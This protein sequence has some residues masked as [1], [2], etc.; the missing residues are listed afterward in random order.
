VES[1]SIDLVIIV[2][3]L[4]FVTLLG[5]RLSGR[6]QNSRDFFLGGRNLPW[7]AVC[8]SIVAT[9]TSTLTFISVPGLAYLTNLNFLQLALGYIIGRIIVSFVFLPAYF[10]GDLKTS[11]ELLYN[12]FGPEVRQLS[13]VLFL[14]T[15][16]L[17]DGV[18]LF[19]TAIPLAILTGWSMPM[20]IVLIAGFT[21]VYTSVGGIR[22]VVWID[23]LQ[24][25]IY[26]G[27]AFI[28]GIYILQHLPGGWSEVVS[29]AA[30]GN[31]FQ[32]I[33][34]GFGGSVSGFF[35]INYTLMSSLLGGAFLSM[36]SHGTDQIIVQR[37]LAC[38]SV[39]DSQKALIL[40]G[41][42]VFVQ[43]AV[44]LVLGLL[45]FA[46][47]HGASMRSDEIFPRFI[48]QSMP[49]GLSG[50]IIASVFAAAMSTLSSSL[51][52]LA[53]SSMYDLFLPRKSLSPAR[54]LLF[55]RLFTVF[56]GVV[57]V[58]GA[59]FFKDKDN[60]VVELGLAISSFTYGGVLGIFFLAIF[61]KKPQKE[62]AL[63]S[64]WATICFMTWFI[65]P[66][67]QVLMLLLFLEILAGVWIFIKTPQ[68]RY[69]TAIAGF[70]I[71]V[72]LM[73]LRLMSPAIAWPWYVPTG[74]AISVS[75]GM[76]L[77]DKKG[78]KAARSPEMK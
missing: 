3:Y 44:F 2:L 27:G 28:A 9:E 7:W 34:L 63:I 62:A 38:R 17:A 26:V 10:R 76:L 66:E 61:Q 70:F 18:R 45:L 33:N 22:S 47:Y 21:I 4:L 67:I 78:S 12:R 14:I 57:F 55:S 72:M 52:S 13:S 1:R 53:S 24:T 73:H 50:F 35:Q 71:L 58:G 51:N 59:L 31:K 60:P 43:F 20:C 39:R 8:L 16:L 32:I 56:W 74:T 75:L 65:R 30:A 48:M 69:K 11:Y 41:L 6:L 5:V 68:R 40:S 42:I 49:V 15:R 54:E 64:L 25:F 29:A 77:H 37:L 19:A 36:A 46:F 23:V